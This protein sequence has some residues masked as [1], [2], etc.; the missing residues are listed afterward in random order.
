LPDELAMARELAP[1]FNLHLLENDTIRIGGAAG[2]IT[3]TGCTLWTDYRLFGAS[4][5]VAAMN[6]ARS[7]LN[8]H[9]QINWSREPWKRF[10]PEEALLLH[11]RSR[12]FLTATLASDAPSVVVTHHGH[13]RSVHPRYQTDI[14][15]AAFA[16]DLSWVFDPSEV[17]RARPP[18]LFVHGH[19][20]CSFDYRVGQTRVLCNPHGYGD[21][22]PDFDP[23]LIVEV[24]T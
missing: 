4:T 18:A 9:R 5:A 8:D 1:S 20:H 24:G 19:T 13:W 7:G 15:T 16:S 14:L 22:N 17:S 21:E 3:F 11:A 12:A 23:S 10:R 6:A 2:G